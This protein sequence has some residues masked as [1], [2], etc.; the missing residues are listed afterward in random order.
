MG[1]VAIGAMGLVVLG[2]ELVGMGILVAG[3]ALRWSALKAGRRIC[4]GLVAG[5]AGNRAVSAEQR[6]ICF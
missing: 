3:L 2:E 5:G 6:V 1:V 4:G